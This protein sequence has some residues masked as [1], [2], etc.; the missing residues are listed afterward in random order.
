GGMRSAQ[1]LTHGYP[2]HKAQFGLGTE[3]AGHAIDDLGVYRPTAGGERD[4]H[5][6]GGTAGQDHDELSELADGDGTFAGDVVHAARLSIARD[7]EQSAIDQIG[8]IGERSAL[9]AVTNDRWR[10]AHQS[11]RQKA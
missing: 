1:T 7:A 5:G 4:E 8:D 2:G 3:D 9:R 11:E 10:G 6:R